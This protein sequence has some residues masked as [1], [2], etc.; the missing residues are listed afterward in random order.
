MNKLTKNLLNSPVK[1]SNPF[2]INKTFSSSSQEQPLVVEELNSSHKI[3]TLNRPYALNALN[4]PMIRSLQSYYKKWEK[5]SE[6]VVIMKGAGDKA[7]CSGGDI[8]A[9]Y[10]AVILKKGDPQITRD[11]FSEEYKLNYSIHKKN[12]TQVSIL[13]GVTMGGGVGL[14]VH[15]KYRIATDSTI[16]AMPETGIGFFPDVGSSYVLSR[17]PNNNGFFSWF[18]WKKTIC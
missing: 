8:R 10:D 5:N 11:F 2:Q 9:I 7:F 3:V 16:F 18:N 15:G 17:L 1:K 4:L 14:S 12:I 6:T 13:N